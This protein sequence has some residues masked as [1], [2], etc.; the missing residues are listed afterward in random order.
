MS[1]NLPIEFIFPTREAA[2]VVL[3]ALQKISQKLKWASV[4]DVY[5]LI[6]RTGHHSYAKLGWVTQDLNRTATARAGS[7]GW[8][9]DF[10][11]LSVVDGVAPEDTRVDFN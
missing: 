6:G 2:E 1:H 3:E 5:D 4:Q 7:T 9:I 8:T 11:A 10:P